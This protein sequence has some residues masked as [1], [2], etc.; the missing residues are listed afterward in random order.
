MKLLFEEESFAIIGS[1]IEVHKKL[2]NGFSEAV[3][4]EVLEK[5]FEKRNVPFERQKELTLQYDG[6]PLQDCYIADFVCFDKIIIDVKFIKE[7][8]VNEI[9]QAVNYLKATN[10]ELGL[11]INFGQDSLKWK[12]IINT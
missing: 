12:R 10:Y 8:L 7:I 2:G 3:Y 6:M 4:V 1:C 5:E 9:K 11:I